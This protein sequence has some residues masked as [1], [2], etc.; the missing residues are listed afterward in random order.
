MQA[1]I[2]AAG[3]GSRLKELTRDNA[4]CMVEVDGVSLIERML[5][6]LEGLKVSRV[7]IVVGYERQRLMEYINSLQIEVPIKY[8][9]NPIYDKTNNI[10]SLAL[11][12]E[13]LLNDDTLLLES[14]LIFEDRM[15]KNLVEDR[16]DSLMLVD[17]YERW[18]DGT[19]VKLDENDNITHFI[20][21]KQLNFAETNQYYKTVNIYKFSKEFA[22]DKYVPAL[23]KYMKEKG[24]NDYYEQVLRVVI[25]LEEPMIWAK[26]L[27]GET[28]YE[29]DDE[30]DLDIAESLFTEDEGKRTTRILNREGGYWRYPKILDF[31]GDSQNEFPTQKLI[32]EI[33]ANFE[34]L[35]IQRPSGR[36][37]HTLLAAKNFGV[38]QAHIVLGNGAETLKQAAINFF[39]KNGIES[40]V[41]MNPDTITGVYLKGPQIKM[42]LESAKQKN[43]M[44]LL[45]ETFIDFAEEEDNTLIKEEY[46]KKYP[47][48]IVVKDIAK[49]YGVPGLQI[50]VLA[51]GREELIEMLKRDDA[52]CTINSFAEYYMQI[53]EKY[54]KD[55]AAGLV[56]F[57]EER[58]RFVEA[59]NGLPGIRAFASQTSC[60]MIEFT[61]GRTAELVTRE[62]Y[63][64]YN[65]L[66]K[67]LTEK[68]GSNRKQ[69]IRIAVR[70]RKENEYLLA[71]LRRS[72]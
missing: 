52:V 2:L 15:L 46:F 24:V 43:N 71:A 14:D 40:R 39:E 33:K 64:R 50:G 51:S 53:V 45:D 44:L 25:G 36:E 57:K 21:G 11:A 48:L 41:V 19:C 42:L 70:D 62:L 22:R 12:K 67:N 63:I 38:S 32:D 56:R 27:E 34:E 1:I 54:K 9:E 49:A 20:P 10:Y 35:L 72:V 69:S 7:I 66:V 31:S 17:K 18:M 58:N 59:L 28:W 29:I 37:V 30:Q 68:T 23:E 65:I 4:K 8:I 55:Y 26:R 47:N 3:M 6:Q 5:R 60:I 61:D 13:E 16:R